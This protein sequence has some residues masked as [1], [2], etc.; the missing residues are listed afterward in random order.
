MEIIRSLKRKT[1]INT[2]NT[3]KLDENT[4]K[5]IDNLGFKVGDKVRHK[6]LA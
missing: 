6:N 3:I 5:V 4:K 1:E 2:K